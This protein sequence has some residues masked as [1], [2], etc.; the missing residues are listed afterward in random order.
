MWAFLFQILS[1]EENSTN[2]HVLNMCKYIAFV[3]IPDD[4]FDFRQRAITIVNFQLI[5]YY[6]CKNCKKKPD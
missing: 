5:S 1:K 3:D 2:A 4:D 6:I